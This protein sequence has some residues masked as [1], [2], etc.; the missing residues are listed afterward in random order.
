MDGIILL[1]VAFIR[2]L[3]VK[4][5][6]KRNNADRIAREKDP[7][8]ALENLIDRLLANPNHLELRNRSPHTPFAV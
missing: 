4:I 2:I 5:G 3:Q 7:D 8:Q 6:V 1:H